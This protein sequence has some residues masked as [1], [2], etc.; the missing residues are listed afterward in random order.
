[1]GS[2]C[3]RINAIV[4]THSWNDADW[5]PVDDEEVEELTPDANNQWI[6]MVC[7]L[8]AQVSLVTIDELRDSQLADAYCKK[9]RDDEALGKTSQF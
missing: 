9:I 1:M 5:D 4:D 3:Q 6:S 8:D 2:N 7:N